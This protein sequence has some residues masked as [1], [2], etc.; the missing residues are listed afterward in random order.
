MVLHTDTV[1]YAFQERLTPKGLGG[2]RD[3]MKQPGGQRAFDAGRGVDVQES[4]IRRVSVSLEDRGRNL[5]SSVTTGYS[6]LG[7]VS[8]RWAVMRE[9]ADGK[10]GNEESIIRSPEILSREA[11]RG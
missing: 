10:P 1:L 8:I 2:I 5:S 7:H 6:Y 3:R 9:N 4:N 11:G